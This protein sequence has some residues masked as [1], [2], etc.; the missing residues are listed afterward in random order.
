MNS[1]LSSDSQK[2]PAVMG[3]AL[4]QAGENQTEPDYSV[5]SAEINGNR[6]IVPV[7]TKMPEQAQQMGLAGDGMTLRFGL[8][9]E[10]G[11]WKIDTQRTQALMM[12]DMSDMLQNIDW[13]KVFE[14]APDG[15]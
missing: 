10:K 8:V 3:Q 7:T 11:A 15:E 4:R 2:V 12:E 1:L 14:S 6:A 9:K 5:G 13:S